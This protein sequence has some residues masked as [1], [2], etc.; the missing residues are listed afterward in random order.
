MS[1]VSLRVGMV[2]VLRVLVKGES[3]KY[4]ARL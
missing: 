4:A 2:L 1:Y 3:S